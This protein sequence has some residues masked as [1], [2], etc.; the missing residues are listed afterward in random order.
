M[1]VIEL[2]NIVL[3]RFYCITILIPTGR[4]FEPIINVDY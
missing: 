3:E 2:D 4:F 1:E